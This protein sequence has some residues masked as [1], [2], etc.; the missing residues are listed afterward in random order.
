MEDS[1]GKPRHVSL[2]HLDYKLTAHQRHVH[3]G[4][5]IPSPHLAVR[6]VLIVVPRLTPACLPQSPLLGEFAV[7]HPVAVRLVDWALAARRDKA[8]NT[9]GVWLRPSL[10]CLGGHTAGK[11]AVALLDMVNAVPFNFSVPQ[12]RWAVADSA[13]PS[14][15]A[16]C[17][18][19][20]WW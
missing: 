16:C 2:I 14:T 5:R 19:W 18:W 15:A 20:W 7:R 4:A 9:L 10:L 8:V 11:P 3:P 1:W 17:R 6:L 13:C 12:V